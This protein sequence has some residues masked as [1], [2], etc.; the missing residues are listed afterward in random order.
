MKMAMKSRFIL[1]YVLAVLPDL[2]DLVESGEIHHSELGVI[3]KMIAVLT[4]T[5]LVVLLWRQYKCMIALT[6]TDSLTGLLNRRSFDEELAKGCSRKDRYDENL[7]LIMLDLDNFKS[8]NDTLGHQVG[9]LLL[10]QFSKALRDSIRTNTDMCFRIGG[11]EFIILMPN[12]S[13][14]QAMSLISRLRDRVKSIDPLWSTTGIG[15]SAGAVSLEKGE[16]ADNFVKRADNLMYTNKQASRR[17][18]FPL[19]A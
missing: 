3:V 16:S 11:D 6:R 12:S 9:D 15:V 4:L 14:L 13:V 10:V 2:L 18:R 5:T 7:T 8:V 1:I 19:E 17:C